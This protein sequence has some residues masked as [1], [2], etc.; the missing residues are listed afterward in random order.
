MQLDEFLKQADQFSL[1]HLPTEGFHPDTRLLSD[2]VDLDLPRA[3]RTVQKID[4][5]ALESALAC[6]KLLEQLESDIHTTL[7]AG[8][9]VFLS[10]CGAT[11]R[12]VLA[13]E[14]TWRKTH[15]PG[16]PHHDSIQALMAGGDFALVKSVENFEDYPD[17]GAR[18]LLDLGFGPQDL[19]IAVTEGGETPYVIGTV[20]AALEISSRPPWFVFCNPAKLLCQTVARSREVIEHPRV[21]SLEIATGPMALSG[22]TRLQAASAQMFAVGA[23]L[24]RQRSTMRHFINE[25][26]RLDLVS[27]LAPVIAWESEVYR[28]EEFVLYRTSTYPIAVLT[29]TTERSPTFSLTAFEKVGETQLLYSWC[30]LS[31]PSADTATSAWNQ[32][33]G[34]APL[35]LNWPE[36]QGKLSLASILEFDFSAATESRR[37]KKLGRKQHLLKMDYYPESAILDFIADDL[38]VQLKTDLVLN[39]LWNQILVKMIL[40]THSLMVMGRMQRY[41]GNIMTWVR[42]SNAKLVDRTAR[43]LEI[44]FE[45]RGLKPIPRP[46]L[47][48]KIFETQQAIEPNE[49][50]ILKI[51]RG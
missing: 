16:H 35:G 25:F 7:S 24:F 6:E 43:Y 34:R 40:N 15:P 22:S 9:R 21:R 31:I 27:F 5:A 37:A 47:V 45:R 48:Q 30:Y 46:E 18:H 2:W 51:L 20:H 32:I 44:L 36:L 42:P 13:L 14:S 28:K 23:A 38:E 39:P 8:G 29:D 1:G 33:L 10:G 17:Y 11:G 41:E 4:V 19:L 12:L 50:V 49:A 3:I 26:A